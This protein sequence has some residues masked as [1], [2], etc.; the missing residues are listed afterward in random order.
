[1]ANIIREDVVQ[2]DLQVDGLDEIK[3]MKEEIEHLKKILTGGVGEDALDDLKDN[4]EKAKKPVKDTKEQV[5]KLRDKLNEVGKKAAT[6]AFNGLKKLASISFK[7]M[8]VGIG[9]AATAIGGLVVKASQSFADL[10]QNQ[11]GIQKL[12]GAGGKSLEDYAK[13]V[14][15][16]VKNAKADY[17]KLIQAEN[18]VFTNANDAYKLG[19]TSNQYM[20]TV[21]SFSASLISD[22]GG[23]TKAAADLANIAIKDMADNANVFGT[24]M[25]TVQTVYQGLAKNQ[26]MLLDNLKLGYG[27]SKEGAEQLVADAAKIDKSIK[28]NDLSFSNMVKAINVMQG[29]MGVLGATE[30]EAA[31]TVTGS[32]NATKAA[33]GNL[34]TAIGSG[35]NLDQ[36]FNNMIESAETFGKNIMPVAERALSGIGVVIEKLAPKIEKGLPKV[37]DTLLPPLLSAASSLLSGLIKALPGIIKTVVKEIPSIVG[38]IGEAL[39]EGITGK[40]VS[41]KAMKGVAITLGS[42][43]GGIVAAIPATKAIKG[44]KKIKELFSKGEGGGEGAGGGKSLFG[45]LFESLAKTKTTTVLKGMANLAIILGGLALVTAALM[46][47]APHMAKLSDGKSLFEVITVMTVLGVVGTALAKFAGGVGMIPVTTVLKGLANIAIVLVGLGALVYAM[48]WVFSGGIEFKEMFQ[49]ISLIGIL[50][51]FGALLSVFA[52]IVGMIP[53][54]IVA[55]GLANMAIVLV[56][57][58]ALLWALKEVFADGVDFGELFQVISLIGILSVVGGVLSTFAAIIGLVPIPIVLAGLTN[59][60][61]VIGGATALIVAFGKL[62]QIDGFT[63]FIQKGG[64]TLALLFGQIGKIG[65]SLIGGIG[66]GISDSLPKIGKNIGDFGKNISPLFKAIKGVDM[67]GVGAFFTAIVGLLGMATGKDII[68]GIKSFFGG[69]DEESPLSKLGTELTDFASNAKGFFDVVATIPAETFPK[70]T[71]LF[72][73]LAQIKNL[74]KANKEGSTA[75]SAIATDLAS[76]DEKAG[77]FFESVKNYDLEKVNSLWE[78]LKGASSVSKNAFSAVKKD[79][80]GIVDKVS[81]LPTQMANGIKASGSALTTALVSIWETAVKATQTPVNKLISGANFVLTQLGSSK[82]LSTWTAYARGTDGHR[83]GNA[84]VN[85]GRGAELIQMPNGRMFIPRGRNV[86]LPNAPKG[87]KVLNAEKTAALMGRRTPTFRYADGVGDIDAF[88]YL[89]N[90]QGL[91]D[92]L[93]SGVT[94]D[95]MNAFSMSLGKGMVTTISGAM[96]SWFK[97]IFD[98]EIAKSLSSYVVGQGVEQWRSTAA[99]AL[100]MEGLYSEANLERLLYQMQTES[101]GN[102]NAINLWDSNAKKGIPSKG[103]MQVI[104]PTFKAYARPGYD[105]NSYDPLSNIL[106]SIRYTTA[107]YGSLDN[108]W[109]GVGYSSGVGTVELPSQPSNLAYAPE[110]TA[111]VTSSN[112]VENNTYAPVMNFNI[113]TNGDTRTLKRDIKKCA[114]EALMELFESMERRNPALQEY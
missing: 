62:S 103:L 70:A 51:T 109:R 33:W 81:K 34:I 64:D 77:G 2:L 11:G 41:G 71:E 57:I 74:P 76:F 68:E 96:V 25:A 16:S 106:A 28:K 24:D 112:R 61:L 46:L 59:I 72:K 49:V 86:L 102:P 39:I 42:V 95:G 31:G 22:L 29:K 15:K 78:S 32:L 108:G 7:G 84:L 48:S 21:T 10:E 12:F 20:E 6:T 54:A 47:V 23:D 73:S 87:M 90:A 13:S 53:V 66:E 52:G 60:G 55:L 105:T 58:G 114:K 80:K 110:S 67:G 85:D 98:T 44:I 65:G 8:V 94:Y 1:M 111:R 9:A 101:G 17:D 37:I 14:N 5:E 50:G 104:D 107:R 26:Y 75:I 36:C 3:K 92:K 45:G 93:T 88:A 19:L 38:Q 56:G 69:G 4:A 82:K 27:G 89:N 97:N 91:V 79:I 30:A 43:I 18:T 63:S 83:G 100:R 35:E 40:E 99:L 113:Y